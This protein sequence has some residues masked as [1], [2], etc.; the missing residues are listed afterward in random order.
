M[1]EEKV[2]IKE[3]EDKYDIRSM[4]ELE[5]QIARMLLLAD[6][7][8]VR[9]ICAIT[10]SQIL[11]FDPIWLMLISNSGGGKTELLNMFSKVPY[12]HFIDTI[13]VN[14]FLS[15]MKSVGKETSLL[16]RVQ[17]GVFFFKDF[18]TILERNE[19]DRREI[20][21][22]FRRIYDGHFVKNTGNGDPL[23]WKGRISAIA[24]STSD[25]YAKLA[26]MASMGERF[27]I[28]E[29][30]QPPRRDAPKKA[31]SRKHENTDPAILREELQNITLSYVNNIRKVLLTDAFDTKKISGELEDEII[32]IADFCSQARTGLVKDNFRH[33][34]EFISSKEMPTRMAEQF[35]SLLMTFI[36][37]DRAENDL[38]PEETRKKDYS[39]ELRKEDKDIAVKTALSSIP[40]K[41]RKALKALA[42]YQFGVTAAGLAVHLGYETDVIKETLAELT[43][44]QLA[45]R[46]KF[47]ATYRFVINE[48]WR[49]LILKVEK[50][51]LKSAALEA[52]D[53]EA[54]EDTKEHNEELD[55]ALGFDEAM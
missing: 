50:L 31:F 40:E 10:I 32:E 17:N 49:N 3:P 55:A 5:K 4:K 15:G 35:Y 27:I 13:T 46:Q 25:V 9:I 14:T 12:I 28:Y 2:A 48:E 21:S 38:K 23:E 54:L 43:A 44:L 33:T 24:C 18:S 26:D 42:Q 37:I 39:G 7:D 30:E 29:M 53:F 45:H 36:A 51:V 52:L 6:K 47:G 22:Q 16:R 1:Q 11:R 8:I 19:T 41:R 20:M 34:I